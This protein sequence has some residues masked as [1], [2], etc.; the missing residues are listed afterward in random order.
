MM[1]DVAKRNRAIKT[2]LEATYGKGNVRV[3][4]GNG[5]ARHWV[6]IKFSVV[7]ND[8]T[9]T[10]GNYSQI[11][12]ALETIIRSAGIEVSDFPADDM[13]GDG[14]LPCMTVSTPR[15]W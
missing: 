13:G 6:Y 5:T 1:I 9:F 7:P 10:H 3:T 2:L 15:V 12:R 14:R 4:A 11:S 8:P